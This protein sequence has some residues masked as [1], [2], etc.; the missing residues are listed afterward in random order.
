MVSAI[1]ELVANLAA[2]SKLGRRTLLRPLSAHITRESWSRRCLFVAARTVWRH[3]AAVGVDLWRQLWLQL[4]QCNHVDCSAGGCVG[5][6]EIWRVAG[7]RDGG[8]EHI[9]TSTR[10]PTAT[11][12]NDLDSTGLLIFLAPLGQ[13]GHIIWTGWWCSL[14][15]IVH[16]N[17]LKIFDW[18]YEMLLLVPIYC[19]VQ[20]KPMQVRGVCV[21]VLT[22]WLSRPQ[23]SPTQ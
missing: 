12:Q 5:A 19:L 11:T 7:R 3:V 21:R 20:A 22:D 6:V 16:I 9:I 17:K 8:G 15:N 4:N 18:R 1:L 13:C 23:W 14:T 10:R 2:W